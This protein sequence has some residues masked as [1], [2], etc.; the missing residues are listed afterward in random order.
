MRRHR[1]D[2]K[3]IG[4]TLR[5]AALILFLIVVL[6][7]LVCLIVR[8]LHLAPY[9]YGLRQNNSPAFY[10]SIFYSCRKFAFSWRSLILM[11]PVVMAACLY[12]I[13]SPGSRRRV[14]IIILI[15]AFLV[16]IALMFVAFVLGHGVL[17][18]DP[19]LAYD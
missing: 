2:R 3:T 18:G 12:Q 6:P 1:G 5:F 10:S 14:A 19:V 4:D 7:H 13:T 15:L 17:L 16:S 11:I 8:F 9:A